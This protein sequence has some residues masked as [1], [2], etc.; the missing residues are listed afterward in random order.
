MLHLLI[1][2]VLLLAVVKVREHRHN[3]AA[4]AELA[5]RR[6]A[7]AAAAKA[8][9]AVRDADYAASMA[10]WRASQAAKEAAWD[11]EHG[12]EEVVVTVDVAAYRAA[13]RQWGLEEAIRSWGDPTTRTASRDAVVFFTTRREARRLGD[14]IV[15]KSYHLGVGMRADVVKVAPLASV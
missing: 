6:E 12:D 8:E 7:A 4:R 9:Q 1:F 13:D 10:A 3:R 14:A 11:D 2:M 5:A 15:A